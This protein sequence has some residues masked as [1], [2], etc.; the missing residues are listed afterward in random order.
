MA[1][2][3]VLR[4][5]KPLLLLSWNRKIG[6]TVVSVVLGIWSVGGQVRQRILMA[7]GAA[8]WLVGAC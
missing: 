7:K 5:R 8:A 3:S 4:E 2:I 6:R 1:I